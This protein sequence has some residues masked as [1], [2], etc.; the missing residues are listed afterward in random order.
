MFFAGSR[1]EKTGTYP[2]VQP[3]GTRIATAR[4][5]L[6]PRPEELRLRG[7][8]PRLDGQRL[9]AIANHYLD[10]PTAFWRL[11]DAN[12][13]VVPDTLAVRPMI[14]IPPQGA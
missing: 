6:P 5:P 7:F 4:L 1:Y 12:N 3:D 2:V 8:H 10:D 9:D 11:A 14:G 13:A